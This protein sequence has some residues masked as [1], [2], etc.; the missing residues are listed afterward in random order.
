MAGGGKR[1]DISSDEG[2]DSFSPVISVDD[3]GVGGSV[4]RGIP[5]DE[6]T[7]QMTA[8]PILRDITVD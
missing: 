1:K 7:L 4:T 2:W 6:N 5:S 3:A 8:G